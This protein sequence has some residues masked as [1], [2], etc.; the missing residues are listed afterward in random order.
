MEI[1]IRKDILTVIA[2]LK[3][4]PAYRA[5]V[6]A[7]DKI[8]KIDAKTASELTLDEAVSRIR[9]EKGTAVSLV[10]LR[11]GED[12]T[13]EIKVV[14]DKIEIP[15][16]ETEKRENGIFIIRLFS[17]SEKS[18]SVFRQALREMIESG[19]DKLILDLR[20]NPGGYLEAAVDISS[21]FLPPGK[22]VVK[23]NFKD[24]NEIVHRSKGY[25]IFGDTPIVILVNGG[26]AS[27]SEIV[28]GALQD[29]G[30]A[31]IV[32]TKTFGKGS[33]QELIPIT[34]ET[35]LKITIARWLT[36]HERSIS[37]AGIE[38]DVMVEPAKED[39]ESLDPQLE[40]AIEIIKGL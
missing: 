33:V 2:P 36:P 23:E 32:G 27:A 39:D 17:F 10:V 22:P 24:K 18:P 28:A 14:R 35:S 9:G 8:L 4:T 30:A 31:K 38:P 5:G 16:L 20:N 25:N 40:K 1:G 13:R 34:P 21:W 37:E 6:K 15:L 3:G 11:N 29:Y 12:Q 19:S 7:G 26:S